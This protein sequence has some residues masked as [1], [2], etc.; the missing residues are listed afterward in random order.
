[1]LNHYLKHINTNQF[2]TPKKSNTFT[3]CV[4]M[5]LNNNKSTEADD[6][7]PHG[8]KGCSRNAGVLDSNPTQG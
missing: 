6:T 5:A 1:M 8:D 4:L 7:K 2:E 3:N